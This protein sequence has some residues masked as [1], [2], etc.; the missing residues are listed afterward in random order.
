M[1]IRVSALPLEDGGEIPAPEPDVFWAAVLE[2][3]TEAGCWLW[4]GA[5]VG[6]VKYTRVRTPDG[7]VL[8]PHHYAWE[9]KRGRFDGELSSVCPV[10]GC[11]NPEHW[12][13][14]VVDLVEDDP[15][16]YKPPRKGRTQTHCKRGHPLEGANLLH[17]GGARR[18]RACHELGRRRERAELAK[19]ERRPKPD[20]ET[21]IRELEI[22]TIAD[23]GRRYGVTEGAVRRWKRVHGL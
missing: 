5:I 22:D 7:R 1:P 12:T 11:V 23:V 8:K 16:L 19:V 3:V 4:A 20:R 9:L 21:L 2:D 10:P 14:V 17:K 18:C 6:R 15:K 13:D